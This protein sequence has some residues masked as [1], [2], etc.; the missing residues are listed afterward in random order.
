LVIL[1]QEVLE[2]RNLQVNI[3]GD[4]ILEE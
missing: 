3:R 1:G 2:L 4:E